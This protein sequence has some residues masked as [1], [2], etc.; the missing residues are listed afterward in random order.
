MRPL[1]FVAA[2]LAL[3]AAAPVLAE[4]TPPHAQPLAEAAAS[5][6]VIVKLREHSSVLRAHTLCAR[7]KS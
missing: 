4:R 6:R 1:S 2:A 7:G 5:A 3:A